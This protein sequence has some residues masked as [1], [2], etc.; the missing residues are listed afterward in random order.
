M[1]KNPTEKD[2]LN[3][4]YWGVICIKTKILKY[5]MKTAGFIDTY[6]LA[7]RTGSHTVQPLKSNE[8]GYDPNLTYKH[9]E[10]IYFD[11]ENPEYFI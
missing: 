7:K 5:T 1:I 4:K 9:I 10:E 3:L 6:F 2:I 11:D 8:A